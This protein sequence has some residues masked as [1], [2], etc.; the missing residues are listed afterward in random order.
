MSHFHFYRCHFFSLIVSAVHTISL[1]VSFIIFN[2]C[3][4]YCYGDISCIGCSFRFILHWNYYRTI[5][6][7]GSYKYCT[8]KVHN[9]V[10]SN[11]FIY[12][13]NSFI[14][15]V[16][17]IILSFFHF[18]VEIYVTDCRL[19]A[20]VFRIQTPMGNWISTSSALPAN[21]SI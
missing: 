12:M 18:G 14:I 13:Y 2:I 11:Q 17:S 4:F 5:P 8:L 10:V 1:I 16:F 20:G 7:F 19:F 9:Y 6:I 21:L 15:I 3:G